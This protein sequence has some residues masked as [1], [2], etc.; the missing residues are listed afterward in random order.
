MLSYHS[1]LVAL[2]LLVYG[3]ALA[4]PKRQSFDL[5]PLEIPDSPHLLNDTWVVHFQ[6]G[7][8][9]EDHV[10]FLGLNVSAEK[11]FMDMGWLPGYSAVF[12]SSVLDA[13]RS[14]SVS[15]GYQ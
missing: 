14:D 1:L 3:D 15:D 7:Y 11:R 12:N 13:V 2:L 6:C 5:A 8:L 4:L 10:A 9:L